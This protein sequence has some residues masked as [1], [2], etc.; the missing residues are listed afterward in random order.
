MKERQEPCQGWWQSLSISACEI[1]LA[2]GTL[3]YTRPHLNWSYFIPFPR[4]FTLALGTELGY[5]RNLQGGLMP[6][7]LLFRTGGGNTL[8]GYSYN[9][10]GVSGSVLGGEALAVSHLEGRF[11]LFGDLGGVVFSDAGNVWNRPADISLLNLKVSAGVGLRYYTPIGP[12]RVDYA[13]R[14]Y[15]E[16]DFGFGQG[17]AILGRNLYFGIGHAF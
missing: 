1:L 14:V 2:G 6:P 3:F 5:L 7:D 4:Q 15:P 12:I 9:E 10:V 16:V 13:A 8:R 17:W 11:P